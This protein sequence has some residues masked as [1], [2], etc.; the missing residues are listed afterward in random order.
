MQSAVWVFKIRPIL[1]LSG[2]IKSGICNNGFEKIVLRKIIALYTV[3]SLFSNE[4]SKK[5]FKWPINEKLLAL[6]I[7]F[8]RDRSMNRGSDPSKPIRG[9]QKN[10]A[11]VLI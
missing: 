9:T 10:R 11:S 2:F 3:L 1:Y 7:E 5:Q 6:V 4:S 8:L